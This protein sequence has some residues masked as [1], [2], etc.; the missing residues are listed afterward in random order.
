MISGSTLGGVLRRTWSYGFLMQDDGPVFLLLLAGVC[1][2]FRRSIIDGMGWYGEHR[3][4]Q[5]IELSDFAVTLFVFW[6][7]HMYNTAAAQGMGPELFQASVAGPASYATA[8][9]CLIWHGMYHDRQ[10]FGLSRQLGWYLLLTDSAVVTHRQSKI[11]IPIACW[12]RRSHPVNILHSL[13]ASTDS[14]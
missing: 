1:G 7:I 3:R 2:F 14:I 13:P 9:L 10:R 12:A 4:Y 11:I 6:R 5:D 8:L